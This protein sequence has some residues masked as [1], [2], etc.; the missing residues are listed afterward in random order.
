M[1]APLSPT[2][3]I[4]NL[5]AVIGAVLLTAL[6]IDRAAGWLGYQPQTFCFVLR[7]A[8]AFAYQIG[9]ILTAIGIIIWAVSMGKSQAGI[10]LALGGVL[11]FIMPLV[12]PYYLGAACIPS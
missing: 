10:S 11:L 8:T 7:Q 1:P 2:R 6:V 4:G 12:V 5:A 9:V 3:I